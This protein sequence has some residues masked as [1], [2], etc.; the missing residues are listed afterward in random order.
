MILANIQN[1][2]LASETTTHETRT[3]VQKGPQK[4]TLSLDNKNPM[5]QIANKFS[6]TRK[7][8]QQQTIQH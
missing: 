5:F 6:K 2:Y 7:P 8:L 4:H 1:P 3:L